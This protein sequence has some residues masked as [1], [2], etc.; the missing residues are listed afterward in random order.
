MALFEKR[1]TVNVSPEVVECDRKLAE[2]NQRRREIVMQVG[3]MFLAGNTVE[4]LE[5]SPYEENAKAV[6]VIDKEVEYQEKR[7]L[8]LQGQ[9]KCE[10][11]GNILVLES[12]FCNK[13]GEKLNPLFAEETLNQRICPKCGGAY[14]EGAVFCTSCGN[15]LREA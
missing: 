12:V 15:K 13:C 2:L 8:A 3:E 7:K 11:C 4:G 14:E 10:K 5:G 9:R 1:D 6:M